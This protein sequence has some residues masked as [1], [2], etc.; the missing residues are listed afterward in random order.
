MN[1]VK[2]V[3]NNFKLFIV[4]INDT[5]YLSTQYNRIVGEVNKDHIGNTNRFIKGVLDIDTERL[6]KEIK[7]EAS[8]EGDE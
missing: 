5:D 7:R 8:E 4:N 2:K 3:G 1:N 6:M